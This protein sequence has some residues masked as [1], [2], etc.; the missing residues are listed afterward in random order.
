MD[1]QTIYKLIDAERL[2]QDGKYAEANKNLGHSEFLA[3]LVE[4]VREVAEVSNNKHLV[5]NIGADLNK[6]ITKKLI[7]VAAVAVQWLEREDI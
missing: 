4:E 5:I 1:R 3:I 7:H 6:E 2:R